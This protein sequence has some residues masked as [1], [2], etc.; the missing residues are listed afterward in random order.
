[1]KLISLI[2]L[3]FLTSCAT[4]YLLPGNRFITPESQGG[5]FRGQVEFQQSGAS[6]LKI[7]TANG[8]VED[9]V[10]YQDVLRTGFLYSNSFFEP[11]DFIWS[12][13][14]GGNSMMGGKFQLIG[15]S[16][17]A[18]GAGHK[19]GAAFL[20][21]GNEHETDDKSVRFKLTG[22]EY[23]LMYGYRIN[24]SILPYASLSLGTHQFTGTISAPGTSLDGIKP[25]LS[26]QS[27]TLS[28]G[29][30]LSYGDFF[31]KLEGSYQK[32]ATSNTKEKQSLFIGYSLGMGW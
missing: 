15:T 19:A 6:L 2:L 31:A 30:E 4:K 17:T 16:R 20:L 11:F 29:I 1:M 14:G 13:T 9:G 24:E 26:T 8:S 3:F 23:V 5:A 10:I 18:K 28:G 21:G 32:S 25:S 12:H 27:T 22:K 7:N